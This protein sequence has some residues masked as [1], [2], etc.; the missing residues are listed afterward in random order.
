MLFKDLK[1]IYA[2]DLHLTAFSLQSGYLNSR[3]YSSI[4]DL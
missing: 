3:P 4:N 1:I 2:D